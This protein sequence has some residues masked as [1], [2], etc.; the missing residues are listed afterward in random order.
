[1]KKKLNN[2]K[3]HDDYELFCMKIHKLASILSKSCELCPFTSL[4]TDFYGFRSDYLCI[5][6]QHN[7]KIDIISVGCGIFDPN[8]I[9]RNCT[10]LVW[11]RFQM[12]F[13]YFVI[14]LYVRDILTSV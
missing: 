13:E 1:M 9:E 6:W 5:G 2:C 3:N 4:I 8:R 10:I 11:V 7:I 14:F 12:K